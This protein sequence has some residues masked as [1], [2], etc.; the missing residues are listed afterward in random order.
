[1]HD[2]IT[3]VRRIVAGVVAGVVALYGG[4]AVALRYRAVPLGQMQVQQYFAVRLK[5]QKVEYMP[6]ATASQTCVHALFPH[7]GYVP[8]WYLSRHLVQQIDVGD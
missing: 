2:R 8:C 1:M 4:D 3:D 5:G 7:Q 6:L